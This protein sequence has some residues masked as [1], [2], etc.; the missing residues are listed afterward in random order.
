MKKKWIRI[1]KNAGSKVLKIKVASNHLFFHEKGNNNRIVELLIMIFFP[2]F[3]I[4]GRIQFLFLGSGIRIQEPEKKRECDR[5]RNTAFLHFILT[6]CQVQRKD[7]AQCILLFC[8]VLY[9]ET[10]PAR[11]RQRQNEKKKGRQHVKNL[12]KMS[13]KEFFIKCSIQ[14]HRTPAR[15]R[16][17]KRDAV[18]ENKYN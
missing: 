6:R 3:V 10:R 8:F 18:K 14:R 13:K 11:Q 7:K 2:L 1:S 16:K 9:R 17:R 15:E 5:I 4:C 12:V